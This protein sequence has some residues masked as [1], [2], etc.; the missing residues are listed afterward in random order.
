MISLV[1]VY[2]DVN[3]C[4]LNDG[5]SF[6]PMLALDLDSIY[7]SIIFEIPILPFL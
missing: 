6:S 4:W 2:G 1:I 3:L 7:L 5:N